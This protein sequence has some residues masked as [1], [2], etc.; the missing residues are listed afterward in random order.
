MAPSVTTVAIELDRLVTFVVDG[1]ALETTD[2]YPCEGKLARTRQP[3]RR[4]IFA[5][6]AK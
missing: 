3:P 6:L 4:P 2:I 5:K 1:C